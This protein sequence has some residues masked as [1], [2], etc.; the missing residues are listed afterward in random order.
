MGM[1][2]WDTAG[3]RRGFYR[4]GEESRSSRAKVKRRVGQAVFINN[5]SK[6]I[7]HRTLGEAFSVYGTVLD[8]YIAYRN[9]SRQGKRTTFAF[10]RF[11]SRSG[12]RKA[13]DFGDGRILDGFRIRVFEERAKARSKS[14][15]AEI[16]NTLKQPFAAFRDNR[17][18]TD[19]VRGVKN[20]HR[21][22][23]GNFR[24]TAKRNEATGEATTNRLG[25]VIVEDK[26]VREQYS[27]SS[28]LF[29]PKPTWKSLSFAGR[30]KPMYNVE[31][32]QDALISEGLI[33]QVCP[34]YGMLSIIRCGNKET[35]SRCWEMRM[36]LIR[37]W[38][39]ELECLEGFEGKRKVKTW[40]VMK[41]VPLQV[42]DEDFFRSVASRWG[43]LVSIDKD[44]LEKNR[45]DLARL[46]ISVQ[47]LADIPDKF[48]VIVN[49]VKQIIKI[50]LEE[51]VEDRVF[52]DGQSPWDS[53]GELNGDFSV[54]PERAPSQVL[55]EIFGDNNIVLENDKEVSVPSFSFNG[56]NNIS[57]ALS[58]SSAAG[59]HDVPI[60]SEEGLFFVQP[61]P[62]IPTQA[63]AE[64]V[65]QDE[66]VS[67]ASRL[68]EVQIGVIDTSQIAGLSQPV[69]F[70]VQADLVPSLP[71]VDGDT[72]SFDKSTRKISRKKK[73]VQQMAKGKKLA[74]KKKIK[75]KRKQVSPTGV[76]IPKSSR[77]NRTNL[78]SLDSGKLD[79]AVLTLELSKDLGVIFEA[80]DERVTSK[81][82]D[83]EEEESV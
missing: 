66:S 12:V 11:N 83:M 24:P 56:T 7:H 80:A 9:P 29:V 4:S 1:R 23:P 62:S 76:K 75:K 64:L 34:W 59:L 30:I 47:R 8:V 44:T 20:F 67:N 18:Y 65:A 63:I 52:L 6:R 49:G 45:F 15:G 43:E 25:V 68:Q 38:F 46:L 36:E 54:S 35:F 40:L 81:F 3:E 58:S 42:W 10:V 53:A 48:A 82:Q 57:A 77:R 5:V 60:V 78:H 28:L 14:Q 37:T 31:L 19:V 26:Q 74:C 17:S 73:A 39:D 32:V 16:S 72:P 22:I 50:G 61:G 51:Y 79:E 55:R 69:L 13:V 21:E 41:E 27:H 71:Y 70:P 2:A 33:V